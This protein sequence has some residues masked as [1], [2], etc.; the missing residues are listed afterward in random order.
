MEDIW[1]MLREMSGT[2]D[3]IV[4]SLRRIAALKEIELKM[5]LATT[6]VGEMDKE[7]WAYWQKRISETL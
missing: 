7:E 6:K 3:E 5:N 4:S 2:L 1:I